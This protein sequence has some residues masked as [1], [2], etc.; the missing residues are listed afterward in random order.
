[1]I[2]EIE[3]IV[4]VHPV[5]DLALVRV[6]T[7]A[8]D[9]AGADLPPAVKLAGPETAP[10]EH[11]YAIG[12]PFTDNENVTPPEV[13]RAIYEDIFKVKRLQPGQFNSMFDEYGVFSH[14]CSTLGGNSGSGI[15][16]LAS[17]R[18]IGVHYKGKYRQANYAVAIWLLKDDD[19]FKDRVS[20]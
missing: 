17:N 2:F 3:S 4:A 1:M 18:I 12:Y 15:V 11:L 16:D 14:D 6:S 13:I 5:Q 10:G 8:I 9:P 19:L 20:F 7:K